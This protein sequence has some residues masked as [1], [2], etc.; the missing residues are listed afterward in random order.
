M[1]ISFLKMYKIVVIQQ[2]CYLSKVISAAYLVCEVV[3]I[4]GLVC[5]QTYRHDMFSDRIVHG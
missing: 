1:C 3:N 2:S 4:S 5:M